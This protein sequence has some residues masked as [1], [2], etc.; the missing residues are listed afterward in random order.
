ML[1]NRLDERTADLL[2]NVGFRRLYAGHAVSEV[3]DELYFVA[4]M[5]LVYSL[6]GSTALTGVAGFLARAPGALGFLFGPL[7]DRAPLGRL[8][9]GSEL[10]QAAVVLA[11]PV[12]AAL[13][14]LTVPVVL[15]V[16]PLLATLKRI[17]D[18]AQNA[19][20]PRLVADRNLVRANSL[21]A[22]SDRAIGALARAGGGAI[23][24]AVGAVTLFAVNAVTFL[25]STLVFAAIAVPRTDKG[26]SPSAREY[27]DDIAE[28]IGI[29]RHSAL[30]HM[31]AGAALATFF[32]GLTTAVLPAFAATFG[33]AGTYGLLLA[34]MTA[35]MLC[36]SLLASWLETVPLG[37]VTSAGFVAGAACWAAAVLSGSP[38]AVVVLFGLAFVPVGSYNVLVSAAL[39]SGV[40]EETL[41]RVT[42]T[43]GS[44]VS[45]VGP[46][47]IL[48]GGVLGDVVGSTLVIGGSAVGFALIAAYWFLVPT[49]RQFPAIDALE[50]NAFAV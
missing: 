47:G 11:V 43:T 13:D 36:G 3:G 46:L 23:I 44:L 29:V 20:V 35:G 40:P 49:L 30:A 34:A 7:V 8:L 14:A 1:R 5:W 12:A 37:L 19:A 16:V 4:A 28:G 15:A 2:G 26:G 31:V 27:V 45:T 21:T 22:T 50:R 32:M 38:L 39:Q 18:P 10:L 41:G 25:A 33:G 6:S 17:S 48:L 42:A 24:A 9:V